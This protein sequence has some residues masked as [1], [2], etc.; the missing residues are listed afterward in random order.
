M[1][2]CA[3][4]EIWKRSV[5]FSEIPMF[6]STSVQKIYN[7]VTGKNSARHSALASGLGLL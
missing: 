2:E 6:L 3:G 4:E 1:M 7:F 5:S